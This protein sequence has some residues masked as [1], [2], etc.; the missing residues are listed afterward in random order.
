MFIFFPP[1]SVCMSAGS[2]FLSFFWPS[3]YWAAFERNVYESLSLRH[4][5]TVHDQWSFFHW[6]DVSLSVFCLFCLIVIAASVRH[7]IFIFRSPLLEL[8]GS[9]YL[10]RGSNS[11][12]A[13]NRTFS[14]SYKRRVAIPMKENQVKPQR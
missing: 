2:V 8:Q 11:F 10:P 1:F 9:F 3:I 6:I 7:I 14:L 12:P 5:K 13:L 4:Y